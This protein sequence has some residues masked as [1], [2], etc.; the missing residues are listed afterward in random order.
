VAGTSIDVPSGVTVSGVDFA[1][2]EGG[3]IEGTILD[4]YGRSIGGVASVFDD[5]NNIV[6]NISV[7]SDGNYITSQGLP[8]GSYYVMASGGTRCVSEV[9][10]DV[11]CL[12]CDPNTGTP[13]TVTEGA[14]TSGVD[15]HL[16]LGGVIAGR[17]YDEVS[18]RG[19][20]SFVEVWNASGAYLKHVTNYGDFAGGYATF[21][22]PSGGY[23]LKTRNWVGYMNEAYGG[24]PCGHECDFS[25]ATLVNVTAGTVTWD[26]DF[27]LAR[28]ATIG[29]TVSNEL[30]QPLGGVDGAIYDTSGR[31]VESWSSDVQGRHV[32]LGSL[33]DGAYY[34]RT[35]NNTGYC[36]E[37]WDDVICVGA[38]DV[39]IGAPIVIDGGSDVS[40]IDFEL[41]ECVPVRKPRGLRIRSK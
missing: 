39:A 17:V 14:T 9:F 28:G 40:G 36:D 7:E 3:R 5:E 20:P 34:S 18:G 24:G 32:S 1:L 27:P 11:T 12:G 10:D 4:V 16:A 31:L 22:L 23:Y 33:P 15:F 41:A 25:G 29:G 26:V 2:H 13:V 37:V 35:K 30:G 38:C 8:T 6:A 19:F 21:G